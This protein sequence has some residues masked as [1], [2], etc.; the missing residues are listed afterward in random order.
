M[1][2]P[3]PLPFMVDILSS[4]DECIMVLSDLG[5]ALGERGHRDSVRL[6]LEL[7]VHQDG[8]G[9]HARQV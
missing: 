9:T 8:L 3:K 7:T 6:L 5:G 2:F 1:V 4:A